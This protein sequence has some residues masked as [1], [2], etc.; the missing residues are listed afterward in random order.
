MSALVII[1]GKLYRIRTNGI[2]FDVI[3]TDSCAAIVI[4]L[5]MLA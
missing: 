2:E 1:P 3:A 5:E 4:A